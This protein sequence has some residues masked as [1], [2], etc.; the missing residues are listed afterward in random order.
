MLHRLVRQGATDSER[1]RRLLDGERQSGLGRRGTGCELV[2]ATAGDGSAPK[3][4]RTAAHRV[5]KFAW[6][7][8][9]VG[10]V[11]DGGHESR[12]VPARI[13]DDALGTLRRRAQE[14]GQLG[15][16]VRPVGG[17]DNGDLRLSMAKS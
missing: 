10:R 3:D 2:F 11:D 9:P 12:R 14:A 7:R 16:V 4:T 8:R 1:R 6:L 15:G 17:T 5:G 13:S